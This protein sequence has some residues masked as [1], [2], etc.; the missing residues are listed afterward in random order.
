MRSAAQ[1]IVFSNTGLC[2]K[3][4]VAGCPAGHARLLL[5]SCHFFSH[6]PEH[7]ASL[8]R[9]YFPNVLFCCDEILSSG[10]SSKHIICL[11]ILRS[12]PFVDLTDEYTGGYSFAPGSLCKDQGPNSI[13]SQ[14]FSPKLCRGHFWIRIRTPE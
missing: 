6:N 11:I 7:R 14:K 10:P 13:T 8:A 3:V 1:L 12:W 4:V 9:D 5:G 2:K